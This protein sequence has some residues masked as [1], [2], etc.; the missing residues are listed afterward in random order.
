MKGDVGA[1]RGQRGCRHRTVLGRSV[2]VLG[3]GGA[4]FWLGFRS[5]GMIGLREGNIA[6]ARCW[7]INP[8]SLEHEG[9]TQF[10]WCARSNRHHWGEVQA[11]L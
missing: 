5:I 3:A 10:C 7:G 9:R 6:N 1:R 11:Y 4:K 8:L 2:G